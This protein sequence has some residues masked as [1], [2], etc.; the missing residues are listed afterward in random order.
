MSTGSDDEATVRSINLSVNDAVEN[1]TL[2]VAV[3]DSKPDAV[4]RVSPQRRVYAYVEIENNINES[5][6]QNATITFVVSRR[7]LDSNR[8]DRDTVELMRFRNGGWV[9]LD[10][11]FVRE[12]GDDVT[13]SAVTP[14]FSVFAITGIKSTSSFRSSSRGG[15]SGAAYIPAAS[16]FPWLFVDRQ[17]VNAVQRL[18]PDA[19]F[20][21]STSERNVVVT[22]V[23]IAVNTETRNA[24]LVAASLRSKPSSIS[25][26]PEGA[27]YRYIGV[28]TDNINKA[29][30]DS[31]TT[32]FAVSK[33][34]MN[35]NNAGNSNIALFAYDNA[36]S[37]W[38]NA[39]V[40]TVNETAENVLFEAETRGS[41]IFAIV[42]RRRES[43]RN[44]RRA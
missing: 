21:F 39:G 10:T 3:A 27:V 1:V 15:S 14:G 8:V 20:V 26:S 2:V 41:E 25:A 31:I 40:R 38:L 32:T 33:E 9:G 7:W 29:F 11:S 22:S 30:I 28:A 34:W 13:F 18:S 17:A 37:S 36:S 4:N 35:A 19:P 6:V 23:A 5:V 44:P 12:R 43:S 16:T 42:S 24:V